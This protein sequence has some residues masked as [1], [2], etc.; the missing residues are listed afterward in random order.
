MFSC[1]NQ[2]PLST[3]SFLKFFDCFFYFFIF[4]LLRL[5]DRLR[6]SLFSHSHCFQFFSGQ[7]CE[8]RFS[9]VCLHVFAVFLAFFFFFF[10][11]F[12]AAVILILLQISY[13]KKSPSLLRIPSISRGGVM[14]KCLWKAHNL[15]PL[16]IGESL[17]TLWQQSHQSGVQRREKKWRRYGGGTNSSPT[18]Y[19]VYKEAGKSWR[20]QDTSRHCCLLSSLCHS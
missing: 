8:S 19:M 10:F 16:L 7:I 3:C 2:T 5:F 20:F 1:P 18:V 13:S 11:F 6:S 17:L 4:L 14:E 12:F 9:H 15:L